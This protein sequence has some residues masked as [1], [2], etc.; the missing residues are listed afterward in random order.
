MNVYY[1][2]VNNVPCL[3]PE[4]LAQHMN[5]LYKDSKDYRSYLQ[6]PAMAQSIKNI[7]IIKSSFDYKIEY[8]KDQ[9][10]YHS[11][12]YDQ[13]FFNK[14]VN[15]RDYE[16]GFISYAE[17][18]IIFFAESDCELELTPPYYHDNDFSN[19]IVLGGRFNCG[20]HFRNLETALIL[21]NDNKIVNIKENDALYYARFHTNDKINFKLF[22]CDPFF[23]NLMKAKLTNRNY[24]NRILP[25]S[26]YYEKSYRKS[27]L[28]RIKDNIL[29]D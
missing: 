28:K 13:S 18:Q 11:D 25:L 26:W 23:D 15:V 9:K 27:I 3:K 2:T 12:N 29:E 24:T 4:P 8:F 19:N 21:K 7:F 1:T 10:R 16:M 17:P 6:C 14:W 22:Y 20:R 5:K